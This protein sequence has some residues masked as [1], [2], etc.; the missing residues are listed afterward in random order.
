MTTSQTPP[1]R[2]TDS[3]GRALIQDSRLSPQSHGHRRDPGQGTRG[4]DL[5]AFSQAIEERDIDYQLA[6]YAADADI[7]IV[8]PDNP[9]AAP[10]TLFGTPAI[11]T[12]LLN[13]NARDLNLRVTHLID[14]GDRVAFTKR[15]H[16]QDGRET[17]AI[18][19]AEVDDGRI[20]TQHTIVVWHQYWNRATIPLDHHDRGG[21][22]PACP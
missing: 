13:S 14:G 5:D 19:T 12:W 11:H 17:V 20:T 4:F 3:S 6:H 1:H 18:N 10:Q 2:N 8:N 15:C 16:D 9:P 21:I 22:D 7:R